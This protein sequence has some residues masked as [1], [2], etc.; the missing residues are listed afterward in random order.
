MNHDNFVGSR[1]VN[2]FTTNENGRLHSFDD[3]PAVVMYDE[4]GKEN[5]WEYFKSGKRHRL[6]GPAFINAEGER[7]YYFNGQNITKHIQSGILA[8]ESNGALSTASIV[9]LNLGAFDA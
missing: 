3:Q 9:T 1:L 2:N 4:D 7:I 5:Q 6:T 8:V